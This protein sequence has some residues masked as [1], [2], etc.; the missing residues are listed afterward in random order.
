MSWKK[1]HH[2]KYILEEQLLS[3]EYTESMV[4]VSYSHSSFCVRSLRREF[5][6]LVVH[7]SSLLSPFF[8]VTCDPLGNESVPCLLQ[9]NNSHLLTTLLLLKGTFLPRKLFGCGRKEIVQNTTTHAQ[10]NSLFSIFS[11]S[12]VLTN[13]HLVWSWKPWE[14]LQILFIAARVQTVLCLVL[15]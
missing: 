1:H 8:L 14:P 3:W 6:S 9:I 10:K 11:L 15:P 4:Y 5:H 2:K 7:L 12:S 13:L